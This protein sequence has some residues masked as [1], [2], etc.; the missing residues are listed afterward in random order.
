MNEELSS[1]DK[2]GTWVLVNKAKG[3]K[4]VRCKW[5]FNPKEEILGVEKAR[6]KVPLVA[7][8][9]T[10]REGIDYNEVFSL[11]VKHPSIRI[12]LPM[13]VQENMELSSLM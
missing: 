3:T 9:F 5:I 7:K 10:Q 11:V 4:L 6:F 1:L 12:V 13:V 8:G 2:N